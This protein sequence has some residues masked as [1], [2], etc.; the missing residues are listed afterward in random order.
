MG[1]GQNALSQL[2]GIPDPDDDGSAEFG[3]Y[4]GSGDLTGT[5]L[6]EEV[7]D[8]A[9]PSIDELTEK[10]RVEVHRFLADLH[11]NILSP[12]RFDEAAELIRR[13]YY[14]VGFFTEHMSRVEGKHY[15]LSCQQACQ[16]H[17][18]DG[19]YKTASNTNSIEENDVSVSWGEYSQKLVSDFKHCLR[20]C[21][22][23]GLSMDH[24][25]ARYEVQCF[26]VGRRAYMHHHR[27]VYGEDTHKPEYYEDRKR[28][29]KFYYFFLEEANQL[30]SSMK[31]K[32]AP[33]YEG[34]GLAEGEQL[35]IVDYRNFLSAF[36]SLNFDKKPRFAKTFAP[37]LEDYRTH[38]GRYL[39]TMAFEIGEHID[40]SSQERRL[41]PFG[42]YIPEKSRRMHTYI[43]GKSGSGKTEL[44][45]SILHAYVT[46]PGYGSV[47]LLDPHGDVAE[48]VA[49]WKEFAVSDQLIYVDP[50][51]KY[52]A[53]PVI[54]PFQLRQRED[55]Q[56]QEHAVS[57]ATSQFV[58][59]FRE[60]MKSESA[61]ITSQMKT[62]LEPCISTVIRRSGTMA[63]LQRFMVDTENADLI[64]SG[65]R[66]PNR[67]HRNFFKTGFGWD[68]YSQTKTSLYTKMQSLFNSEA[69]YNLV[70][71]EST[72]DLEDVLNRKKVVVFNLSRGVMGEEASDA[73]GRF[74]VGMILSLGLQRQ[75]VTEN[76]R[77][78]VHA[79]IDECQHYV[80]D[81]LEGIL[82]ECRKYKIY[83][84][85]AQQIVG[86]SMNTQMKRIV[87]GGGVDVKIA[88]MN[89]PSSLNAYARATGAHRE[90]LD[91]LGVGQ[92]YVKCGNQRAY[93]FTAPD[94]LLGRKNKMTRSEWEAVKQGQIEKYY[95]STQHDPGE[96]DQ[97]GGPTPREEKRAPKYTRFD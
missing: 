83:L 25:L 79:F 73:F 89:E 85:L 84:T 97:A 24:L 82:T 4:I 54:N 6:A 75:R 63:D 33:V 86:Q 37:T 26:E 43:T 92:F 21:D 67:A 59:V 20:A 19:E 16:L 31:E 64:R 93:P 56:E 29:E 61:P 34:L 62:L 45:K 51:L 60:L 1:N 50:Y 74:I 78:P 81:S 22:W 38:I 87:L 35:E 13:M 94:T 15:D 40:A 91:R 17:F 57:L 7:D 66:S 90:D 69:F 41:E 42:A 48:Q 70:V 27:L 55:P 49:E 46:R 39:P 36:K 12:A 8:N 14:T 18:P 32:Y 52:G 77:V 9:P 28:Y 10:I 71:G 88:G 11:D 76:D 53:C 3:I 30:L 23:V 95:R 80:S 2:L 44:L 47:V 5:A 68:K 72:I 96:E 65:L 58:G